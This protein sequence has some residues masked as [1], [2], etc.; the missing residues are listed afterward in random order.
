LIVGDY[1]ERKFV[2]QAITGMLL[3]FL[4]VSFLFAI[5]GY[6]N[7][8][9]FGSE[10]VSSPLLSIVKNI[11]LILLLFYFK[12]SSVSLSLCSEENFSK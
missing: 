5:Y 11:L 2:F 6:N 12:H 4:F 8:G 3:I 10:I 1:I 7:C 9:C